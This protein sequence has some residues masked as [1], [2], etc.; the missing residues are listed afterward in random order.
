MKR[1]LIT[2][3]FLF[4]LLVTSNAQ[5]MLVW[6]WSF[7]ELSGTFTT[8]GTEYMTG[9]IYVLDVLTVTNTGTTGLPA[10]N[11]LDTYVQMEPGD[12][13]FLY[14]ADTNNFTFLV[15]DSPS[16]FWSFFLSSD[17]EVGL[18]FVT[19]IAIGPLGTWKNGEVEGFGPL[20]VT[21]P[22]PIPAAAWL[23]MSGLVGLI[24]KGRKARQAV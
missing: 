14:A 3:L 2:S 17:M 18:G 5:A 13:E 20:T 1:L 8:D 24:W 6:N 19:N 4:S 23:F 7:D 21:A 10:G 22:V 9:T 12:Y 11:T 15:P 16:N